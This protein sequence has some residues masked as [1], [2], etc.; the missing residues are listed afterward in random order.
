MLTS[1]TKVRERKSILSGLKDGRIDVLIGTHAVLSPELEFNNLA[2][3]IV[4][5]EHRFGADQKEL[6]A[7]YDRP[8]PITCL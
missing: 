6:L 1:E 2:L 5:E 3:T 7:A 4:D 8:A